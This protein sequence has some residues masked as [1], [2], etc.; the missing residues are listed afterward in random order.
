MVTREMGA[1]ISSSREECGEDMGEKK[2]EKLQKPKEL[3]SSIS[4]QHPP[5]WPIE[6]QVRELTMIVL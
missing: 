4:L 5:K 1:F 3:F 6:C 2:M